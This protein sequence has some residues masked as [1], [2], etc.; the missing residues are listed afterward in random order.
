MGHKHPHNTCEVTSRKVFRIL[1]KVF[2][3]LFIYLFIFIFF[4][5][6]FFV[7][8]MKHPL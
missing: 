4:S 7:D 3:Y 6:L 1:N 8:D 5:F 2:I